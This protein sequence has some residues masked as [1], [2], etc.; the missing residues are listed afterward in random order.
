MLTTL[1]AL[2]LT[3][4]FS[5]TIVE[6]ALT[7]VGRDTVAGAVVRLAAVC[8]GLVIP[9]AIVSGLAGLVADDGEAE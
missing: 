4:T 6:A 3:V 9:W 7:L 1:I 8:T 5:Y 2:T